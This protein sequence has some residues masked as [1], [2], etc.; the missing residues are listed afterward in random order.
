M[1]NNRAKSRSSHHLKSGKSNLFLKEFGFFTVWESKNLRSQMLIGDYETAVKTKVNCA[2][3]SLWEGQVMTLNCKRRARLR[4]I[5]SLSRPASLIPSPHPSSC[6]L[7]TLNMCSTLTCFEGN[8]LIKKKKLLG[9][10]K[11]HSSLKTAAKTPS[12]FI[13]L[14]SFPLRRLNA[15]IAVSHLIMCKKRV[16]NIL[17]SS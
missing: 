1:R 6:Y 9:M 2:P 17:G 12:T 8:E 15:D 13:V 10:K 5:F 3:C 14:G 16:K 4:K 7:N 11:V